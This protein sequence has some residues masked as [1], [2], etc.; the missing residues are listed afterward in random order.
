MQYK[1][2]EIRLKGLESIEN[3]ANGINGKIIRKG[4]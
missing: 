1:D 3:V 4:T 2:S